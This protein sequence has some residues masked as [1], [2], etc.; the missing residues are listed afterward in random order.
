MPR[1]P[2]RISVN[3]ES[4]LAA[5]MARASA[6]RTALMVETDGRACARAAPRAA[7]RR[8]FLKLAAAGGLVLAGGARLRAPSGPVLA[9]PAAAG[10]TEALL[11]NCMDYRLVNEVTTYMNERGMA[12]KYD[13]VILAGAALA[14][15]SV[16]F[17]GWGE[18]FWEH[19]QAAIDL[20]QIHRVIAM[21]HRDCG[22][23]RLAYGRD[24]GTDPA[25]ETAIH[26]AVLGQ[27]RAEVN[28]RHPELEV[29]T[30][31][32]DLGGRVET[33]GGAAPSAPAHP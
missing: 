10:G 12:N 19:L 3:P 26:T 33:I 23:F 25:A 4:D 11:L 17:P 30:L 5:L 32:M 8:R 27:F 13:Q 21:D 24:F 31:L 28:A 22:A 20:H 2:S 16:K 29:E 18:T 9:A 7:G 14:P 6:E 15:G 1:T